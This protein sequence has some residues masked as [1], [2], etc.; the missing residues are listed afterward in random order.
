MAKD[1]ER[2]VGFAGYGDHRDDTL[3]HT[4][5]VYALYILKEY[6]GTCVGRQLMEV[7][8][9]RLADSPHVALW[10]LKNNAC[11]ICFYQKCG[12]DFDGEEVALDLGAP[13]MEVRMCRE[14]TKE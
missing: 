8:L 1:G 13:A 5:E 6:Y 2:V 10:V 9:S 7:A 3:P 11:A 4:G 14:I 12:F